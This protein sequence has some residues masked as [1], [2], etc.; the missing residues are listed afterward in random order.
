MLYAPRDVA[1]ASFAAAPLACLVMRWRS[2]L[3]RSSGGV[4]WRCF[5]PLVADWF[6]IYFQILSR[7]FP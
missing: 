6:S 2:F 5:L 7:R 3:A 4:S 1:V